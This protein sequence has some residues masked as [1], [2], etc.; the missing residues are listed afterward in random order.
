MSKKVGLLFGLNYEG[1]RNALRGCINDVTNMSKVLE[2][3]GFDCEINTTASTTDARSIMSKLYA[4]ASRSHTEELTHVWIHY[5]GHGTYIFD[6][7]NDE[8]DGKDECI[9]PSDMKLIQDDFIKSIFNSFN[10]N[11]RIVF[12]A[13]CCHSGTVA[14]LRYN[15]DHVT[16]CTVNEHHHS[17]NKIVCIS[18]CRDDQTSADAYLY[19]IHDSKYEFA[20][21]MTSHLIEIIDIHKAIRMFDIIHKLNLI[22]AQKRYSQRP[23]LSSSYKLD[24]ISELF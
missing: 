18:G 9:V 19:N 22:L 3:H 2:K 6:S 10:K 24:D 16:K 12:I 4:I 14:D 5:S 17:N 8:L 13:D 11:T 20:G 23:R 1:T 21:A 15:Y 7:N